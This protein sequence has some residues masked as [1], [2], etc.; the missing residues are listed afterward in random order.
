MDFDEALS[1]ERSNHFVRCIGIYLELGAESAH[2][3]K[4]V[5]GPHLT[6]DCRFSRGVHDLLPE[7]NARFEFEPKRDQ[8]LYY[9]R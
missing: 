8:R 7:R 5:A 4:W 1:Q 2:G 6:G 9:Y 3:R